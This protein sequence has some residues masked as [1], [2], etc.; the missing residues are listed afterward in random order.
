MQTL[1]D[2]P[3]LLKAMLLAERARA[4]RLEQIIKAMQR[5]RFGRKAESLPEDQLLLGLEEAE[6]AEAAEGAQHEQADPAE[7][8][9]RAAQRRRNRGSLPAHLPR[10]ETII[11]IEDPACPCCR[12]LLHRIGED[13]SERLDIVP[14][15]LRVLVV[16]RPKYACR[17]CEDGVVQ[18]PAP[19]RVIE[20]GLPT[21]A[22]VAQVL[23]SKY[24]DHLPLYRQSQIYARQGITLDRS[25]LADWVGRAAWHLRP[26]HDRLL[27]Q[28][29]ASSRLFADETT[30]PVLDPGR[31]QTKTGQ[32]FAYARDD[33]PW[34]GT[35]PPGV[36]Y[37]YAPDR[38][39]VRPIEHLSGFAG[40]LQVDGYSGYR[41]L[42]G[43]NQ[44]TL[45]FC[46]AH[47]RRRFYELAVAGAAPIA[48]EA[49]TRIA[50]L[51]RIESEIRGIGAA[52][53]T[54][55]R[56]QK[57]RPVLDALEPWLRAKLGLISQKSKLAEAIRYAL[58]RW[59]GL[60]RF[61]E[62]GRIEI[63]SNVVERAIRPLALTRK[64]ALFAGS[65]RGGEHWAIIASLVE[66]CKLCGVDPQ[67]Y[68]S[69]VLS[70]IV[71]G[72]LNTRI[73]DLL[74]WAYA[75]APDLKAVA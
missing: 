35:D 68:L 42:A 69:D 16:R 72:H 74:P 60:S 62:D 30:A 73:D 21:D 52:E 56:Q 20:G 15:Q 12:N 34:G 13:V 3:D 25:T 4:E 8:K 1:P 5:H 17:H 19:A 36:A 53:R 14:A 41:A 39:A 45:A 59:E 61:V 57:S 31:G 28:L 33:R 46:W 47:V 51:Y 29:K 63:D 55:I 75:T 43:G 54:R 22:L 23:V 50:E 37:V 24:A 2:D 10:I 58:S 9:H 67:A 71:A 18:A 40:V 65:D 64:N 6:Q 38:K 11:D 32:L 26:V 48:S 7:R 27:A 44:V 49:L 70:R 66:T